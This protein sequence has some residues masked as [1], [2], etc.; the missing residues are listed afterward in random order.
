L[1]LF[2]DD[3]L[4]SPALLL[5]V[6]GSNSKVPCFQAISSFLP[7]ALSS[8]RGTSPFKGLLSGCDRFHRCYCMMILPPV[9]AWRSAKEAKPPVRGGGAPEVTGHPSQLSTDPQ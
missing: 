3:F 7:N 6:F 5:T 8:A 4:K 1:L 2:P 9:T